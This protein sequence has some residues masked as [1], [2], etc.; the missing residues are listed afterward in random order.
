MLSR[1]VL[2]ASRLN[3]FLKGKSN[4]RKVSDGKDFVELRTEQILSSVGFTGFHLDNRSSTDILLPDNSVDV[5]ITDPPYGS[6]VHYA[7]LTNY[8]AVW[9]PEMGMGDLIS[10]DEEAVVARKKFEG[11][12]NFDDYR[13]ILQRCFMECQRVLKPDSYM[14]L[15]FN[16]REPASWAALMIAA[17][18][19][20]FILPEGGLMYQP[21]PNAYRHTTNNRRAGSLRGDFIFSF[22][23]QINL[24]EGNES[25]QRIVDLF[26]EDEIVETIRYVLLENGSMNP[27]DLFTELYVRIVPAIYQRIFSTST[28][29]DE[30]TR[31]IE[32]VA[33]IEILDSEKRDK[34]KKYFD[35]NDGYWSI[36]GV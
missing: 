23:N 16:N 15:T 3:A 10:T 21:G 33:E 35:Y 5:V 36:R 32:R 13:E 25:S 18:N 19:S 17:K 27:E 34:L 22:S 28:D 8:W 31:M 26:T 12:K 2:S 9:L 29:E 4:L 11:G 30:I 1:H 24:A 7:D 20:G 14:V 6:Y